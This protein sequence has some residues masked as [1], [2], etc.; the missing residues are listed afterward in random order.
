MCMSNECGEEYDFVFS[1]RSI[2]SSNHTFFRCNIPSPL[3]STTQHMLFQPHIPSSSSLLIHP[4]NPRSSTLNPQPANTTPI[5]S[6]KLPSQALTPHRTHS[7]QAQSPGRTT[8]GSPGPAVRNMNLTARMKTCET[9]YAG[10]FWG[11]CL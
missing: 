1:S 7:S 6:T 2:E 8:P 11:V 5:P 4:I 9:W 10:C 3:F